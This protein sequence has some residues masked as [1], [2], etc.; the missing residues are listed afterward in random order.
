MK[1][2]RYVVLAILLMGSPAL[3]YADGLPVD[4]QMDVSDPR[5]VEACPNPIGEGQG[6][7][8]TSNAQGGGLF[9]ATNQSDTDLSTTIASDSVAST[10]S[11]NAI[12]GSYTVTTT[13]SDGSTIT[14]QH[15]N[16]A[17]SDS[18]SATGFT[19]RLESLVS[20]SLSGT[21]RLFQ[22][23]PLSQLLSTRR[24]KRCLAAPEFR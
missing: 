6:F 1:P 9:T 15:S 21:T 5:C 24:H 3:T 16:G 8:F 13:A 12:T 2:A 10:E 23:P 22:Q 4:P 19:H 20:P 18:R 11:G 17:Y 14:D 7:L